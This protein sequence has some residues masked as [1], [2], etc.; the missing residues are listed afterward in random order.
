M[1]LEDKIRVR[2]YSWGDTWWY[3]LPSGIVCRVDGPSDA[4]KDWETLREYYPV[5]FLYY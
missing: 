4:P 5:P 2:C 3:L 1:E